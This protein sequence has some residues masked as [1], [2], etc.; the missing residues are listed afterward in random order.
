MH[1]RLGVARL[2]AQA[3]LGQELDS[4]D[5]RERGLGDD[6]LG[7]VLLDALLVVGDLVQVHLAL[8]AVLLARHVG[9]GSRL[10]DVLLA[11]LVRVGRRGGDDVAR[12]DH[13]VADLDLLGLVDVDRTEDLHG[14]HELVTQ[15]VLEGRLLDAL[16]TVGVVG[17]LD[18]LF[19]LDMAD[20]DLADALGEEEL[21]E[22]GERLDGMDR[23]VLEHDGGVVA[24]LDRGPDAEAEADTLGAG[25]LQI[26]AVADADLVDLVEEVIGRVACVEV[27]HAGLDA[28]AGERVLADL[29]ELGAESVLVVAELLAA[30]VHGVGRVR[31]GQRHGGVEIVRLRLERGLQKRRVEVGRAQVADDVDAVLL[32]QGGDLVGL[33]GVDLL[34]H[35][36][37]IVDPGGDCLGTGLVVVGQDHLLEPIALGVAS[38]GDR[39]DGLAD[40]AGTHN[41]DLHERHSFSRVE[42]GRAASSAASVLPYT[43]RRRV[44]NPASRLLD[45][46]VCP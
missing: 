14:L 43:Q 17:D 9:T 2:A 38:F 32:G 5:R 8:H 30:L 7:A 36:P 23:A 10:A 42:A 24:L 18:D 39:G 19:V 33:A 16:K 27:G 11:D 3:A 15:G 34:G 12:S 35:E 22:L 31:R 40:T 45:E 28:E 4:D 41:K 46:H 37:R 6:D 13:D 26:G 20:L 1:A 44:G 29:L 21:L 25:D